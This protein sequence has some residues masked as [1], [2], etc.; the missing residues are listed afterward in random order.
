[1]DVATDKWSKVKLLFD[2]ALQ[3]QHE[4][5][6]AYLAR[7]CS[8]EEIRALVQKLLLYHDEANGFLEDSQPARV[9]AYLVNQHF[10]FLPGDVLAERFRIIRLI[11]KGGMGEVYE[12]DDLELHTNVAI[13]TIRPDFLQNP[14]AL[15]R[16]KREVQ[17]AK[18]VTHENVCRI[19]DLFRHHAANSG[20]I[21][22]SG[23]YFVS[24]ELLQGETLADYLQRNGRM[25]TQ[26][27]LP[28]VAQIASAL[29][30]AHAAGILHRDLKPG[31]VVLVPSKQKDIARLVVTDFGL[32]TRREG[33]VGASLLLTTENEALGTPAYMSP[34]QFLDG[35]LTPASDIYSF[36][37]VVYEMVTGARPVEAGTPFSM[38]LRRLTEP[39]P[40]PKTIVRDLDTRWERVILKCLERDPANR[41]ANAKDVVQA[42]TGKQSVTSVLESGNG[43]SLDVSHALPSKGML[44][45]LS[46]RR[47]AHFWLIAGMLAVILIAGVYNLNLMST[48][49]VR[50][51][52]STELTS[53]GR[54]KSAL[55]TDGVRVYFLEREPE[56][57]RLASVPVNG[58]AISVL[59]LA[60]EDTE[61]FDIS[62]ERSEVLAARNVSKKDGWDL[63][64]LPL[65]AGSPRRVGNLRATSA[66]WSRDK[67]RIASILG[68]GL[69]ISSSDGTRT[70][71]IANTM[72]QGAQ[73]LR[74]SPDEK[75][76]R[77]SVGEYRDGDT[78]RSAWEIDADGS[79]LRQ[80]LPEWNKPLRTSAGSWTP[81][82]S[83][84][85]FYA[86]Q[87]SHDG[88]W[89][90]SER[91]TLFGRR[92]SLPVKLSQD[93]LDMG[94][95]VVGRDGS[96]A[97]AFGEQQHGEL[98]RYDSRLHDY[99]KF[100][101]GLSA[102]WVTFSRSRRSVAYINPGDRTIWRAKP[103]GSEQTQITFSPFQADGLSWSPDEKW[104]AVRGR[105]TPGTSYKVFIVPL[106]GGEP[107]LLMQGE[108]E[109]GL[110]TWSP[111]GSRLCFGDVPSHFGTPTGTEFIH[112]FDLRN[113][114][115]TNLPG[116]R[117]LWTS[118]WS[119]NGRYIAA[120]TIEGFDQELKLFDFKANK[121]LSTKAAH[122]NNPS[123]TSDSAFIYY[124]TEP[125]DRRVRR[126]HIRDGSVDELADLRDFRGFGDWWCGLSPNNDPLLLR[127]VSWTE[128]YSLSLEYQ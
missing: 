80:F 76:L 22:G 10:M 113:H 87:N 41:F 1:M 102:I 73:E 62:P 26:E 44:E 14:H 50:V 93:S 79:S 51:A 99:V 74:W 52:N 39:V 53:N 82:G 114:R 112:I 13:K 59:P 18:Q 120:V 123:W 55:F 43:D 48:Q 56:G 46:L 90:I 72:P 20:A 107:R 25:T 105:L 30:A 38:G 92:T 28:L 12:A 127:K 29:S 126:I 21:Q 109:Q 16:F 115:A 19:F 100:L 8:E 71:Q 36:G 24:M 63:W 103:D 49:M 66:V 60:V 4:A 3:L 33:E 65:W 106:E 57:L 78:H 121:W 9:A 31:N 75:L 32:A 68:S 97:F 15:D 67:T 6:A 2:E 94:E 89:A 11:A 85:F 61:I 37:L 96:R 35:T 116:S 86:T 70:R 17:L 95:P 40:S 34:E 91:R 5:R 108:G 125:A 122:V 27:A 101:G 54:T 88:L 7:K 69:F 47:R 111:D 98:V 118:R 83:F 84:Y 117:G 81:D 42:L 124:D 58:G 23:V 128:V 119:P 104:L 77:F 110:A 64:V 45:A